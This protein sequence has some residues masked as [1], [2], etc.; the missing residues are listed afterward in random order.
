[1]AFLNG[2]S[3]SILG[4]I[5]KVG[6]VSAIALGTL[7]MTWYNLQ[8]NKLLLE[9]IDSRLDAAST[10]MGVFSAK[11]STDHAL[12]ADDASLRLQLLRQICLN[13]A[14]TDAARTSCNAR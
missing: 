12:L 2:D 6:V 9:R 14:K 11:V 1:M 13:T 4:F 10:A 7:G 5:A 3:N 8:E